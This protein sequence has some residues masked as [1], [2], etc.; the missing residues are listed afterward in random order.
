MNPPTRAFM[1][2]FIETIIFRTLDILTKSRIKTDWSITLPLNE[3]PVSYK[4]DTRA[5]CNNIPL[6]SEHKVIHI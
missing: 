2:F 4:I 3:I 6:T 5:Q 1:N